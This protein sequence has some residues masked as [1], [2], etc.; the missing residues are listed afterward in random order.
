MEERRRKGRRW[1]S[2][3]WRRGRGGLEGGG[4][5]DGAKEVEERR[6]RSKDG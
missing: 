3:R 4:T 2:R 6:W 1:R 5:W